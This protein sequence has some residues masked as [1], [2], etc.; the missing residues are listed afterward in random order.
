MT[1]KPIKIWTSYKK[2]ER[3]CVRYIFPQTKWRNDI[4]YNH[5]KVINFN[6]LDRGI[7]CYK[8]FN[9]F[10]KKSFPNLEALFLHQQLH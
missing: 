1:I 4:W 5:I 9:Y 7:Y 3:C 2:E 8:Q 6:Y 10:L